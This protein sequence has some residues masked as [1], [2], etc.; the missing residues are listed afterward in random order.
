MPLAKASADKGKFGPAHLESCATDAF[1]AQDI[2]EVAASLSKVEE[3]INVKKL[4]KER[5]DLDGELE[6]TR[7]Y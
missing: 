7:G 2:A 4:A 6:D 3:L 5:N 1:V